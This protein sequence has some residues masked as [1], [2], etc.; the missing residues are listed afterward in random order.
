MAQRLTQ[1]RITPSGA[2]GRDVT[3]IG[4]Y[5]DIGET[6]HVGA[7][8]LFRIDLEILWHVVNVSKS[9]QG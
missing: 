6:D 1:H 7:I 4:M 9:V 8:G 5:R 2:L 3:F